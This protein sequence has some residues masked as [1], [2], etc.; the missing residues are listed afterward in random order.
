MSEFPPGWA[1][2]TLEELAAPEPF[3]ITDGP[4]GSSLKTEHYVASGAR[5]IRLTNVGD[6]S[7][8]DGNAAY[9][10]EAHFAH[11]LKHQALPGDLVTAAL[12]DPLGRTCIV[13]E[14][15]RLA[16]VK[17]DCF[18]FRCHPVIN[19]D[20]LH[21]WLNSPEVRQSFVERSHGI[22]RLRINLRDFRV[23]P[24]LLPPA[25][26]QH[27]IVAKLD[28][29][30][31]RS[32]RARAELSRIANLVETAKRAVMESVFGQ[33]S[34]P[35]ARLESVIDE[36]PSN[37]WSPK[38]GPDACGA[39]TLKLT[40]TT[41]GRMRLDDA[42]TKRIYE[43]PPPTSP[44][45]LTP[46]DLLIQRSN[47]IEYV[48]MAAIYDGPPQAYIYP[49]L[50]MR[51]RIHDPIL[52][53]F[54]WRFLSCSGARDYL[55]R[56]ATGT[57]GNM[58]KINGAVVRNLQVPVPSATEM[59]RVTSEVDSA[60]SCFNTIAAEV[61]SA[62]AL[63]DRLD[64][65]ILT[66]AFRGELVPQDQN[67]EPASVLLDRIRASLTAEAKTPARRRRPNRGS[68]TALD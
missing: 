64:Q 30:S 28:A 67:D 20:Y 16:I 56:N 7:F 5:V 13:P 59:E 9:I 47:S 40:A 41:S 45:W 21:G 49:D 25:A 36:G 37:G 2:T 34:W 44:Y 15:V 52:R 60:F 17:A 6:G 46:G 33:P 65:A 14:D 26:E 61:R 66:K 55:R 10:S 32:N 1:E 43:T 58:P 57:A 62:T 35:T 54:I 29:L 12:G 50:M 11:L 18:R 27:R 3:A 51:I 4:F 39:L 8:L 19:K 38:S 42:A 63:L 22:G 24:V 68:A 48:G 23:T 31:S 53:K